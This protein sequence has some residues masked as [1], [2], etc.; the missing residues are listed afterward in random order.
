[1]AQ[2][3]HK[4]HMEGK[5]VADEMNGKGGEGRGTG[6]RTGACNCAPAAL[7][8]TSGSPSGIRVSGR[9]SSAWASHEPGHH[10][11]ECTPAEKPNPKEP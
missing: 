1:M 2:G 5:R 8:A 10:Q 6:P 4:V 9:H 11:S 3:G 7:K